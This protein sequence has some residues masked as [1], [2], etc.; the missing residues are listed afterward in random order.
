MSLEVDL[1]AETKSGQHA[2][3]DLVGLDE[4]YSIYIVSTL[5][6]ERPALCN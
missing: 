5:G 6:S 4:V 2:R 3:K 1:R